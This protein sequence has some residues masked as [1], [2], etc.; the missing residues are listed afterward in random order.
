MN[1]TIAV[2]YLPNG[3]SKA[4][5]T[6]PG[7]TLPFVGGKAI[8]HSELDMPHVLAMPEARVQIS[9]DWAEWLPKWVD[10]V[11]GYEDKIKAKVDILPNPDA[12][13]EAAMPAIAM[14]TVE[15]SARFGVEKATVPDVGQGLP[16]HKPTCGCGV[17]DKI[18]SKRARVQAAA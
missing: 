11:P 3:V 2:C 5:R 1:S 6:F 7:H 18:R 10:Q 15:A 17:C 12:E 13:P 8:V 14:I 9:H 4:V 16:S